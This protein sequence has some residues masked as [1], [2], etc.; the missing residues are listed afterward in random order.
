VA[1]ITVDPAEPERAAVDIAAQVI[2]GGGVVGCPTDTLYGLAA[3][4]TSST[5]VAQLFVL[6]GRDAASAIPVVAADLAQVVSVVGRL[7]PMAIR[8]AEHFWPGPLSLIVDARPALAAGIHAGRGTVAVRVPALAVTRLLVE[9][10]GV[11]LTATSANR[12]GQ[13]AA[14]T[15]RDVQA[16]FGDALPVILDAG[17]APGAVPSTIVDVTG[18]A[19]RLVRAG[20]I[21]WERV[22]ES[23]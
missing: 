5:A 11:P 20:A 23:L 13:P 1:L 2:R 22:L 12:S 19:P 7:S 3:D 6:K 14:R 9:L 21:D 8:V 10:A 4:A 18:A 15:A 17:P 16:S